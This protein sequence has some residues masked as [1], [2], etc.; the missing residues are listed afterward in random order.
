[1]MVEARPL[2]LERL[3][4]WPIVK[5]M[6]FSLRSSTKPRSRAREVSLVGL[7]TVDLLTQTGP[8][9]RS[10]L[11]VA[12]CC[13]YSDVALAPLRYSARTFCVA[14]SRWCGF[15]KSTFVSCTASKQ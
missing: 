8:L 11:T 14:A 15:W 13:T 7:G 12:A 5:R 3:R 2:T 6:F 1:M 10:T 9:T 4:V